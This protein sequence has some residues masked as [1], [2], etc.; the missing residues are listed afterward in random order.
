MA[1]TDIDFSLIKKG[2]ITKGSASVSFSDYLNEFSTALDERLN[3]LIPVN[4][5][6]HPVLPNIEYCKGLSLLFTQNSLQKII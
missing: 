5:G 4:D 2:M 3:M 6:S 1:W